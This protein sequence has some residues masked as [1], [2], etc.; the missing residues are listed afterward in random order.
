M[1]QSSL[2]A[3]SG[4]YHIKER[5]FSRLLRANGLEN[6]SPAQTRILMALWIQDDVP[7]RHLAQLTSLDKSTLSLS[8]SR[9]EQNGVILARGR[10]GGQARGARQAHRAWPQLP[11][12]LR[13]GHEGARRHPLRPNPPRRA[14]DVPVGVAPHFRKYL[15]PGG[16]PGLGLTPCPLDKAAGPWYIPCW[17]LADPFV[18][19]NF[20]RYLHVGPCVHPLSNRIG[21]PRF[22]NQTPA[23]LDQ[24]PGLVG[25]CLRR[26]RREEGR[27]WWTLQSS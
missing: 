8:L 2:L 15:P 27:A 7:V 24:T 20:R 16:P 23:N 10:S 26:W 17:R 6:M 12:L 14:G 1:L 11:L 21:S 3:L 18:P 25:V 5:I 4:V 9:M 19:I 22:P 13:P